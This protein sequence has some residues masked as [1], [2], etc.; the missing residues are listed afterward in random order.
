MASLLL[1]PRRPLCDQRLALPSGRSTPEPRQRLRSILE[2]A[3]QAAAAGNHASAEEHL[4][5]A[6]LIQE[7]TLGPL[8]PDLANTLNNLGVVCEITNK[9]IDAEHC[10]RRA[11]TIATAVL[12]PDHPFVATSRKNLHDFCAARGKEVELPTP[13]PEMTAR[14]PLVKKRS[15]GRLA[16]GVLGPVVMLIV[17]LAAGRPWLGATEGA[18]LSSATARE[19]ARDTPAPPQA[20]VSVDTIAEPQ[21]SAKTIEDKPAY[22]NASQIAAAS[23]PSLP[24]VVGAQLCAKLDE[25]RCDTPKGPIPQGPLFFYTQVKSANATR[26]LHYWYQGDRLRHSV[27]LGIQASP[28]VGYRSFSRN[29]MDADSVGNWR[30]EVRTEDGVL[31]HEERF[32]VR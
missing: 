10:F 30:V 18:A 31:L 24:T 15:Y 4:R 2:A 29:T 19:T 13:L 12:E 9:P 7:K 26:I 23:T 6:A 27:V 3:E 11:L 5:R 20:P 25:W 28:N 8:H 32:S 22:T 21:A 17:I 14:Q 16:I 1:C